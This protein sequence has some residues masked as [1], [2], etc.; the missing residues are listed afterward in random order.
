MGTAASLHV[1]DDVSDEVADAAWLDVLISLDDNEQIF[2]TYIP[3][4]EISRINDGTLHVL[5]A[6]PSVLEVLDSCT[7]LE[8]RSGGVFCVR[9]R[10]GDIDPAGFVK[11]WATEIASKRLAAHGLFNWYLGVGGDI[12]TAG[13]QADGEL[14]S[15]GVLDPYDQNLVR[16]RVEVPENWAIAT[17]G[18]SQRGAHIWN[19]SGSPIDA[20]HSFTVVG[21]TLTWADAYATIGFAM[22]DAGANW[23]E[24]FDGYA[25]F[26]IN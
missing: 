10:N 13:R 21:P 16:C 22:G 20:T 24:Q 3:T 7:W 18:T 14:W 15:F 5:D 9:R 6:S 4:S 25:A 1:A 17:S 8:H 23:V 19:P 26:S 12:Q 11:G 2:S